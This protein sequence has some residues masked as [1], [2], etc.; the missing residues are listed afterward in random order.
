MASLDLLVVPSTPVDATPRVIMQAFAAKVPVVAFANEGFRELIDDGR[1]G[2]LTEVRTPEGL[3]RKI[4]EVLGDPR[5]GEVAERAF[6]EWRERFS[7]AAYRKN[8]LG[9]LERPD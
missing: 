8:I 5:R 1:T 7:L 4:V 9:L 6:C 2:F 3:A